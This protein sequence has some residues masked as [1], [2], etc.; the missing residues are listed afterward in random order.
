MQDAKAGYGLHACTCSPD[1]L[2][3]GLPLLQVPERE[4]AKVD[5]V[6]ASASK[7]EDDGQGEDEKPS[8]AH[9]LQQRLSLWWTTGRPS[10][11]VGTL[12]CNVPRSG[13]ASM[14]RRSAKMCACMQACRGRCGDRAMGSVAPA[15]DDA[16]APNEAD[17]V[18]SVRGDEEQ[19][20]PPVKAMPPDYAI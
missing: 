8:W 10:R 4:V 17:L 16:Q 18:D 3:V 19:A 5:C 2:R 13:A 7:G 6:E 12:R 11:A 15:L 9:R 20:L 1:T 14:Q